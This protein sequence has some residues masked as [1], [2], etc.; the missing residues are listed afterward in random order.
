MRVRFLIEFFLYATQPAA[1]AIERTKALRIAYYFLL[2]IFVAFLMA[3]VMTASI[4]EV[5]RATSAKL[6]H[7]P[8]GVVAEKRGADLKI[9]GL[10]QPLTLADGNF[11]VTI[12]TTRTVPARP[13]TTTVFIS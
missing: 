11:V 2:H 8:A 1:L 7:L 13:T 9:T 3:L 6:Q 12:D 10:D 5:I 4:T